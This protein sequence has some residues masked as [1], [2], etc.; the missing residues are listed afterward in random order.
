[1]KKILAPDWL[2]GGVIFNEARNSGL[3]ILKENLG[4]G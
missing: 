2:G 1:M 4:D 3:K